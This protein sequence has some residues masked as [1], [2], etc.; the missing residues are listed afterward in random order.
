MGSSLA[1]L[2]YH[3][4]F[5][6]EE[7]VSLITP[8]F[9]QRLYDY[10]GGVITNAKGR[11]LSAGGTRDHIHLL[12]SLRPKPAVADILRDVKANSSKWIHETYPDLRSFAWQDGYGAFTVSYSHLDQVRR[13]IAQQETHHARKTFQ[14]EF[15]QFLERHGIEYDPQYIWR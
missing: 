14:E 9:R 4:I 8:D 5:S 10:I 6:T 12:T 7:R 3:L 15:I 13:Y 1:C 11:L 2:H